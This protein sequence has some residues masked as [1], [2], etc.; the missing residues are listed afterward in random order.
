MKKI[1]SFILAALMLAISV[2]AASEYELPEVPVGKKFS[3][4]EA[5]RWSYDSV[6]YAYN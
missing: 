2:S 4:V 3:D 5:G 6:Y 1:I